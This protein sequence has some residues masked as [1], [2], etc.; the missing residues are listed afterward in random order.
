MIGSQF[1]GSG[2]HGQAYALARVRGW[3]VVAGLASSGCS[4]LSPAPGTQYAQPAAAPASSAGS[5]QTADP[6][7][8]STIPVIVQ[9]RL[10][11]A[12]KGVPQ[13]SWID[14]ELNGPSIHAFAACKALVEK[15]TSMKLPPELRVEVARP[16]SH[17]AI[18]E[19]PATTRFALVRVQRYDKVDL[20][21]AL[22]P[23]ALPA[24][25]MDQVRVRRRELSGYDDE[26]S[27]IAMRDRLE[28]D[29]T[30]AEK[31]ARAKAVEWLEG[32]I[33]KTRAEADVLCKKSLDSA[34]CR[35][36][37]E[38]SSILEKRKAQE[39]PGPSPA[40]APSAICRQR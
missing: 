18:A 19:P 1:H 34:A 33:A 12:V 9:A 28:T 21:L 39:E 25:A 27:C 29:R 2:C 36:A 31:E 35:N 15:E 17:E 40:T 10:R 14:F 23:D 24:E 5:V 20:T 3:I 13:D 8:S 22:G 32:A 6:R 7:L 38:L 11:F 4:L 37:R 30:R 26:A 16:C